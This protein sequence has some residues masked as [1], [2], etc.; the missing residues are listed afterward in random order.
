MNHA[1]RRTFFKKALSLVGFAAAAN[2]GVYLVGSS[3]ESLG[4]KLTAGAKSWQWATN[5]NNIT[6]NS[7]SACGIG[8]G[9]CFELGAECNDNPTPLP[10]ACEMSGGGYAP[11]CLR[12]MP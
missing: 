7:C 1:N 3:F 5:C 2:T 4:G 9:N 6:Y 12:C 8:G 10:V 11:T